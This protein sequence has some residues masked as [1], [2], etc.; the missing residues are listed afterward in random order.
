VEGGR[1]LAVVV[2]SLRAVIVRPRVAFGGKCRRG[3]L[4]SS[5]GALMRLFAPNDNRRD[6]NR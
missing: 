1:K 6:V 4:T 2:I 3:F 5:A